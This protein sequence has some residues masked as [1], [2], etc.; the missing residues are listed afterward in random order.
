[1]S[2][3]CGESGTHMEEDSLYFNDISSNGCK[4]L[5]DFVLVWEEKPN[6]TSF[7]GNA[8]KR[9]TYLA[10]LRKAGLEMEEGENIE[11]N[12]IY[13]LKLHVPQDILKKFAEILK[14]R[15]ALKKS[16]HTNLKNSRKV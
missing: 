9:Q 11:A 14:M 4:K 6:S 13:F 7:E 1:M 2:V 5:I 3:E 12:S 8:A 16:I 10:E 15:M